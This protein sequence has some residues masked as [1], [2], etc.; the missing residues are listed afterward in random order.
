MAPRSLWRKDGSSGRP[1]RTVILFVTDLHGAE[2]TFRKLVKSLDIWKPHVLIVGG[3]VAGKAL[4]P[5]I[6]DGKQWRLEWMGQ[7]QIVDEDN[8]AKFSG[9]AEQLGYYLYQTT[10]NEVHALRADPELLESTV[11]KLILARWT[12][13]LERLE[14]RCGSLRI[15]AYVIAGN[16]DPWSLDGPLAEEREW[17]K[18][19]DGRMLALGEDYYVMSCGLANETPWRC[20]RDVSE[21]ELEQTLR[22]VASEIADSTNVIANIHVPPYDS[23]L[24]MGPR[25]DTTYNPPRP[26]VGESAPVGSRAVDRFL[27][28]YQPLLSLHG[29]IHESPGVVSIGRT[30]ALNPGSQYSEGMLR[31]ALVTLEPGRVVGHQLV[32]G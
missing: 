7:E 27:R 18:G 1:S 11:E 30:V 3:D 2:P 24:D 17:V 28:D 6:E 32:C 13:W 14:E 10:A 29:H 19:A 15:P 26:T 16:D 23:S 12:S 31:G 22:R 9:L 20:P 21:E 8:L 25:L 4:L 5:V